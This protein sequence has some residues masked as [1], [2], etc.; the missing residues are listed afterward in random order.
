M[1]TVILGSQHVVP[2]VAMQAGFQFS[3]P[4]LTPT[5]RNLLS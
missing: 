4:E 5:L 3:W 2:E 1:A